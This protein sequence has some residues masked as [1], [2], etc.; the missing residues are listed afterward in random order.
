MSRL[1][2]RLF[3]FGDLEADRWIVS[4]PTRGSF[5]IFARGSYFGA[6]RGDAVGLCRRST[7]IARSALAAR[8]PCSSTK[9]ILG[10]SSSLDCHAFVFVILPF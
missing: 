6:V 1:S 3:Y 7:T 8:E 9:P 4:K 2:G 10:S 5:R